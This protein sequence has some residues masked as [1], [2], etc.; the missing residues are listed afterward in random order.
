MRNAE[1]E[2]LNMTDLLNSP[3]VGTAVVAVLSLA[4]GFFG[5]TILRKNTFVS[6]LPDEDFPE[7]AGAKTSAEIEANDIE[8]PMAV[9][10]TRAGRK[11]HYRK[12][13]KA[14]LH[15]RVKGKPTLCGAEAHHDL[16]D[17]NPEATCVTCNEALTKFGYPFI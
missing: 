9:C 8:E 16:E 10:A 2:G 17:Q 1:N 3:Y 15:K 11:T 6:Q 13:G 12:L 14:G 7:G 5:I 4:I